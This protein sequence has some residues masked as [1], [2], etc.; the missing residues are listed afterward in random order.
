LLTEIDKL[1]KTKPLFPFRKVTPQIEE[2]TAI[3][4]IFGG[5][6]RSQITCHNCHEKINNFE[7]FLDLSLDLTQV[8]TIERSL[9]NFTKIDIIGSDPE[10]RYSCSK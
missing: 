2:S 8:D 9:K 10:N 4:Q 6:I 7:A 5:K 3:S 1:Q